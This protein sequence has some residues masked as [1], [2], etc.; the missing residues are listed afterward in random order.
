M[1]LTEQSL[2]RQTTPETLRRQYRYP[3]V[4]EAMLEVTSPLPAGFPL[5]SLRRIAPAHFDSSDPITT[6]DDVVVGYEHAS[7]SVPEVLRLRTDLCSYHRLSPYSGWEEWTP[8]A[9]DC[10]QRF[11]SLTQAREVRQLSVRY[12]NYVDLPTA[13]ELSDYLLTAPV[14]PPGVPQNLAGFF[15]HTT[16]RLHDPDTFVILRQGMIE[17]PTD[18]AARIVLDVQ[19][20]LQRRGGTL[21]FDQVVETLERLHDHEVDVFERCITNRTRDLFQ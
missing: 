5:E 21:P 2:E 12:V 20:L 13:A 11:L 18:K 15:V 16:I 19:A 8:R 14:V 3:P 9:Y 6:D 10:V 17:P 1:P 7:L 4:R